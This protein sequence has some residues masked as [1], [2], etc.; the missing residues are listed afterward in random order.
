VEEDIGW[1]RGKEK[2]KDIRT[3]ILYRRRCVENGKPTVDNHYYISNRALD[4]EEAAHIIRRYR[5]ITTRVFPVPRLI[6]AHF[7]KCKIADHTGKVL[8]KKEVAYILLL[9]S[10]F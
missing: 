8:T 5:S 1:L 2:W 10:Y 3:I 7:S 9:T 4:A 6:L